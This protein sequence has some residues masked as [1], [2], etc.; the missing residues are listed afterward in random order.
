MTSRMRQ[1]GGTEGLRDSGMEGLCSVPS[2]RLSVSLSFR[3][4]VFLHQSRTI[5]P[6]SAGKTKA[7]A[8]NGVILPDLL[9]KRIATTLQI[10][11]AQTMIKPAL[12]APRHS[13]C[14]RE[15]IAPMTAHTPT[16][17]PKTP[18][19]ARLNHSDEGH[20]ASPLI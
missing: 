1:E 7:P 11:P 16:H 12:R 9:E 2:P 10:A 18:I 15:A 17:R 4:S 5:K 13:A 20:W 14:F 3:P 19:P 8:A 6:T